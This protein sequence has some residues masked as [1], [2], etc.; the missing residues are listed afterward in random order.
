MTYKEEI[1]LS[2]DFYNTIDFTKFIDCDSHRVNIKD[3]MN[4]L[5]EYY[6]NHPK[7]LPIEFEGFLF[8][9]ISEYEFAEYLNKRY[10]Y[11]IETVV[12]EE[13]YLIK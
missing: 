2:E 4:S 7:L 12:V 3:L 9:F 8:N 13:Y 11:K 10:G 6:N 1:K 5:E